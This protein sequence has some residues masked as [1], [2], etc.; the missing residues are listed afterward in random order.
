[1]KL[2]KAPADRIIANFVILRDDPKFF[3]EK[4]FSIA[5]R[6]SPP[7][8]QFMRLTGCKMRR[9]VGDRQA[10]KLLFANFALRIQLIVIH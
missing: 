8:G 6:A 1:M 3:D 10:A 9:N 4:T 2:R 5:T 7:D